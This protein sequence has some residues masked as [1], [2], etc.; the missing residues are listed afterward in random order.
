MKKLFPALLATCVSSVCLAQV[1]GNI[2]YQNQIQYS[3]NNIELGLPA[4]SNLL[5]TV[6]GLA[7]IKADNY[8]AIFN[9]SQAGKTTEEVNNLL[10]S[11][12][13]QAI[14][15]LKSKPGVETFVDM[16]SF[17]PVY[18]FEAEKK[19]FNK[20]SYNE[21]PKGFE[22]KKNIHIKYS[23]PNLLNEIIT[24]LSSAEIFDLVRVDY[25]SSKIEAAKEELVNK[26]RIL[27]QEKMK[28]YRQILGSKIDSSEKKLVDGFRIVYPV[29][30]Y[31][32]YQAYSNS[33]LNLKKAANT[34]FAEKSTTLY[35]QPIIDKEFDFVINPV[36]LEP[37][38]QILY[39][40][41][42]ELIREPKAGW[43]DY[44]F[45]TPNGDM[46]KFDFRN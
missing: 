18:E 35:Y 14:S 5:V 20:K 42:T 41:K 6:K 22:L 2:N 3:E 43:K 25:Y 33:E 29:E 8:V 10:E 19:I 44:F 13:N 40:I 34:T 38:I 15:A 21:V 1:S 37:V 23:D 17:V 46:K 27:V 11:R 4:S 31:K 30:M 16:I 26:S 32:S 24:I 9:V 12:M 39:E 28:N 45:I 7:N 36:V